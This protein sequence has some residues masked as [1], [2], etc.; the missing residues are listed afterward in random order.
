LALLVAIADAQPRPPTAPARPILIR[1]VTVEGNRRVQEAVILGRIRS[2]VGSPFNPSQTSEDLRSIFTLG[3]F[4]D[5]QM[6]VEDF[7]GGVK[8]TF[9]VVE[10]P[11][12]RDL[13]F[14]GNSRIGTTE[15]QEKIELKLGSV[16]NPVEVQRAREKL[17]DAYEDEG[18]YEIQISPEVEK[19]EDGDV[20][21]VFTINEGR[22][23]TIDE[24][25]IRGNKGLKDKDIKNAM[26]TR[27][28]QYFILRG[29]V[30]RQKL[31]EDM[32]RIVGVY[33]DHGF[34]QMRVEKYDV[35]V[36]R[37]KARVT[38]TID[39][40][41]GAQYRIGA[42]KV[43]GVTLLPEEEVRRQLGLKSGAVFSRS[44]LRDGV[45]NITDLYS[46][47]G[48]AS[49]DVI[50]RT[51]QQGAGT[52]DVAVDITEGPEVYV[53]RI[54]ITGNTRSEDRI[55]RREI[56][57]V[58]G[59]LFTLQKLQ[60]ARQ[61]L[62]NL[63]YFETVNVTTQP[64]TD[65]TRIIVNVEVTERPTGIFSIGG[66]FSSVDSFVGTLD[67]SQNNFLGRGWQLS[68]RL[69]AGANS[70]Q[71]V[72]SFT[73]PWLFDRPLSAG[74]DLF[75]V[76]RDYTEYDY[77]SLGGTVRLSHPFAEYWRWQTSYRLTSDDISDVQG[78]DPLV[79]EEEG[80]RL[81]SAITLGLTRD[82]RDVV[83]A[84]TKGGFTVITVDFA[85]LGGDSHFVK[86]VGSTAYFKPIWLGHILSGR[87]EV[88]YGFGWDEDGLTGRKEL[89]IFERFYLGGPNSIRSFKARRISPVDD[90]G[91]RIGGTSEVLGNV[92]YIVPLP[93]NFRAAAFFDIGNVYGFSTKF[94]LTDT[95]EAAGAGLRWQ[96]PFGPIRVDYGINLDRRK[97]EDFGAIQFSVGS[98]F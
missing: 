83:A 1:E 4:D 84:P 91:V 58:E 14:V 36:D 88:G 44:A 72:I 38:I 73:E 87:V 68:L 89:P 27:E 54:N 30:Q 71:G 21:V 92:E 39:I 11:F 32:E 16:Y 8:I 31:E 96:S 61:R 6:K 60:R 20:K 45:R 70:Q 25:V 43:A 40:V 79:Q 53:E 3:F 50:P 77:D 98:P 46:T 69:R 35:S 63:G 22:R 41:E 5:V 49:A 18:Y 23:I 29:T 56:P 81:T 15:L 55:L 78:D 51:D 52:I 57:F 13:E 75:N 47:I 66:G 82:S 67:I 95:R 28:R 94:D 93:F 80:T 74:F 12:V 10:R 7:E 62:V 33:Q 26:A 59:D 97:G 34:V 17:R 19:F 9:V 37:E 76:R 65:K 42:I 90:E 2:S 64:G 24:I 86:T 85:G 48:R